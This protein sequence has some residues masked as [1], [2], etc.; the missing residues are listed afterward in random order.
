M[1]FIKRNFGR[2]HDWLMAWDEQCGT[3][4]IGSR[5]KAMSFTTRE[6]ADTACA[7]ANATCIGFQGAPMPEGMHF[8]VFEENPSIDK[9]EQDLLNAGY[10]LGE[11]PG[12]KFVIADPLDDAEGFSLVLDNRE[13]MIQ[14]AHQHIFVG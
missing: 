3:S 7:R 11:L 12:G 4:C 8:V 6:E 13:A 5:S 2:S 9:L 14:E 10:Y 1:F